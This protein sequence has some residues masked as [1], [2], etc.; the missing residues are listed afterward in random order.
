MKLF[1]FSVFFTFLMGGCSF[2]GLIPQNT[3]PSNVVVQKIDRDDIKEVMR[4]ENLL[5]APEDM[6]FTASGEGL[7]PQNVV[8][9]AQAQI[10]AK[11][12]AM[13]AAYANLAGK[14]YGVKID[15]ED[16]VKDAMLQNSRIS[17]RVHGLVKNASITEEG[18][19][20]GLYKVNLQLR[21]SH[22][23]W[24]EVFAY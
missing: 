18:F 15:G 7:A 2:N 21:I 4:Q 5:S 10:L 14:L 17:S 24:Q 13:T 16:T 1:I 23:K 6:I 22:E 8:S 3:Q 11:R 12:A 20:N 19:A 9:V